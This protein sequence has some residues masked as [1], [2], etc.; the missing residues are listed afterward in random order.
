MIALVKILLVVFMLSFFSN[1]AVKQV[2]E[3]EI[4]T[5]KGIKVP[6]GYT[7]K[8][9]NRYSSW[10]RNIALSSD[11]T[12]YYFDGRKKTNQSIHV[13][14]LNYD[15]GN[16]DLQ[17]CADACMRI[18]AEYLYAQKEYSE[19]KFLFANGKKPVFSSYTSKR[20]YKSF[21]SFMNYVFA[22]AN[23]RSL[24]K[25][26][27]KVANSNEV[28]IGDVF[29]QSGNPYGH[30]VTVMDICENAQGERRMMLSQSYMPAQSIEIL[31]NE[32][33]NSAWFPVKFGQFLNT[34]EWTFTANDLFRF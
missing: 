20:D 25:Q 22:F 30:A 5:V 32:R 19:I 10:I 13:A 24:K 16:R 15:I 3:S 2:K 6:K 12:V 17:Q 14:V 29:I 1:G 26:L 8:P 27:K 23:T 9:V 21:R 18:R 11:N 31:K 34:P 4:K 33:N 28:R 7:R